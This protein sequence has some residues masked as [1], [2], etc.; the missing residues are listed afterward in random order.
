[1]PWTPRVPRKCKGDISTACAVASSW[2]PRRGVS[3]CIAAGRP[4]ASGESKSEPPLRHRR[5]TEQARTELARA[6][7]HSIGKS[8][9][10]VEQIVGSVDESSE[11]HLK[12]QRPGCPRCR[13]YQTGHRWQATYGSLEV[14]AGPEGKII[15]LSERPA[16]WKGVWALGCNLCAEALAR[17][18]VLG[19]T[20]WTQ[21]SKGAKERRTGR[22]NC[23]W[24]RY[25]ARPSFLQAEHVKQHA[26]SDIH[27]LAVHA[28][29]R[30]D[31]PVRLSLQRDHSDDQLLH[32]AVPQLQDWVRVWR[33][34]WEGDSWAS[35]ERHAHTENWMDQ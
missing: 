27:K 34:A 10:S 2:R 6:G 13:W 5:A 24:A 9:Q 29:L 26:C 19:D 1:M 32:G 23:S 15:W 16:R 7:Q 14:E 17:R 20:A 4:G 12:R 31:A 33:W 30:P 22:T 21:K 25:E 35:V 11:A 28:F 3:D 8:G 18:Q